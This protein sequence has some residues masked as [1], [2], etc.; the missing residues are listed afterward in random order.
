MT[1]RGRLRGAVFALCGLPLCAQAAAPRFE[2][3]VLPILERR[4][5]RCHKAA[6]ADTSGRVQHPKGGLRLDGRAHFLR[7]G[8]GGAVLV[9]GS[10][11]DSEIYQRVILT[12]EDPDYMPSKGQGL[13]ADEIET[14]RRWIE[15]GAAFGTWKGA[16]DALPEV[17]EAP[18]TTA[19]LPVPSRL[20]AYALLA[21]GLAQP[22]AAQLERLQKLGARVDP[23]LRRDDRRL[24]RVAF[25][26]GASK[27][28]REELAAVAAVR[29]HIVEIELARAEFDESTLCAELARMPRLVRVDLR[30]TDVRGP[31]LARLA[32]LE[33]LD[34]L[35]LFGCREL[36][37]DAIP[38]LSQLTRLQRL[39][40]WQ[41]GLSEAGIE[42]LRQA[43]PAATV[44]GAPALPSPP[45]EAERPGPRRR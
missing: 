25:P 12:P 2:Q 19:G 15:S 21:G 39:H 31:G 7:G 38:Q 20:E 29:S 23:V 4:C 41:S 22:P 32:G 6:E 9:P 28:G 34:A 45:V 5:M 27:V 8:D 35:N 11:A 10:L 24:L 16:A 18:E 36:T 3:D 44:H 1:V 37:D 14:L 30:E 40:V 17:V 13:T 42:R 26:S 33:H 43:L